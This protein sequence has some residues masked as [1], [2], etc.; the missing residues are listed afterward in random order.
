MR[1]TTLIGIGSRQVEC[2]RS[3][4]MYTS[5]KI[6]SYVVLFL[7]VAAAAYSFGISVVHWSGISV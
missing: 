4:R 7:M 3:N 6:L 2:R 5:L 1:S